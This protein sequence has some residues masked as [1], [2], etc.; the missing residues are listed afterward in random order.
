M[1]NLIR[2]K[3]IIGSANFGLNYGIKNNFNKLSFEKIK[4]ILKYAEKNKIQMIDTASSY[5]DAE[6]KI[7]KVKL[8]NFKYISKVKI[9][10]KKRKDIKKEISRQFNKTLKN[11]NKKKI[12]AVL[13]HNLLRLNNYQLK[14][15]FEFLHILKKN[16]KIS[17]LGFSTYGDYKIKFILSRFSVDIIQTSLNVLDD[18]AFS[19][20]LLKLY[21]RK[22]IKIHAR[23]IFLQGL[24]ISQ[25]LNVPKKI[26]NEWN[27]NKKIWFDFC[28][29]KKFDPIKLAVNYVLQRKNVDKF[30]LGFDLKDQ[31][32]N[33]LNMKNQKIEFANLNFKKIDRVINPYLW[34]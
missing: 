28:K 5:G 24:L 31:L 10:K 16:K 18:R 13:I 25:K 26:K 33:I 17:K 14:S 3:L 22:K 11:L 8:K 21:K 9:T 29:E 19:K 1:N 4:K 34:F 2:K 6:L 32:V 7:G 23:S 15:A 30:I 20:E 12:Y 27:K